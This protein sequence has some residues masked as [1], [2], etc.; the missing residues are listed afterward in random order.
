[1][2]FGLNGG[3]VYGRMAFGLCGVFVHGRTAVG[4]GGGLWHAFGAA[5]IHPMGH[6]M[7]YIH[8]NY[9]G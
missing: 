8:H 2:A 5:I 4:P 1:M 7:R 6:M 3:V 9:P